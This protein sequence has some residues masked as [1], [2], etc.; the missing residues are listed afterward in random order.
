[1][2]VLPEFPEEFATLL[3]QVHPGDLAVPC[4]KVGGSR[5]RGARLPAFYTFANPRRKENE[6]TGSPPFPFRGATRPPDWRWRLI[7]MRLGEYKTIVAGRTPEKTNAPLCG[8]A[9]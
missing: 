1:V 3:Q 4:S 5:R 8:P 9:E 2:E 6:G 7:P